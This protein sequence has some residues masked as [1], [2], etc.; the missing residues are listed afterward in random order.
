MELMGKTAATFVQQ[1]VTKNVTKL[2][3]VVFVVR[4]STESLVGKVVP[5]PVM[6]E[7]AIR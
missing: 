4:V 6:K 2:L 5:S 7:D 1:A 3:A